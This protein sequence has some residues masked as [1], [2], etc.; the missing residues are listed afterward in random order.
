MELNLKIAG[1]L[2]ISLAFGH[3]VFPKYFKWKEELPLI[4]L[5]NRQLMYIHTF[6]IAL[7]LLLTGLLCLTSAK[8]IME[9]NLGNKLSLGLA[10]FWTIRLIIQLFGY[11]PK[12]WR[13]KR[14]ETVI[15]LL[16]LLLWAYLAVVFFYV[17]FKTT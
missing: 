11:S 17:Y 16:F 7:V 9:T 3:L 8:E 10:I 5:I 6:F 1:S 12:L 2:L 14:F 15:H 4:S 13:G